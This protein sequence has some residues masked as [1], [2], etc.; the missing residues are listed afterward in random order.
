MFVCVGMQFGLLQDSSEVKNVF[1]RITCLV[2]FFNAVSY[3]SQ[4][5]LFP[6]KTVFTVEGM[7]V[8]GVATAGGWQ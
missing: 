7:S 1:I 6:V 3:F 2:M 8:C 5:R 4:S